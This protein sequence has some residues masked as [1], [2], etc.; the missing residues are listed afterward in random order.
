MAPEWRAVCLPPVLMNEKLPGPFYGL[1][2]VD[3][4]SRTI[5]SCPRRAG[6]HHLFDERRK[7]ELE[8]LSW[9]AVWNADLPIHSLPAEVLLQIFKE[10]LP[11]ADPSTK[12]LCFRNDGYVSRST[13]KRPWTRLMGVCRQWCALIRNAECFWGDIVDSEDPHW[14]KTALPRLGKGFLRARLNDDRHLEGTIPILLKHADQLKHLNISARVAESNSDPL[15]SLLNSPLPVLASLQMSLQ[16]SYHHEHPLGRLCFPD[17]SYPSLT[18]L[19][20]TRMSLS[21]TTSLLGHLRTLSLSSCELSTPSLALS[22]FLDILGDGQHLEDLSLDRFLSAALSPQ[23]F[24]SRVRLVALPKLRRLRLTET[25]F[26]IARLLG[27]INVPNTC[28]IFLSG[29]SS[30]YD[31]DPVSFISMLPQE[32][33]RIAFVGFTTDV[34]FV[35]TRLDNVIYCRSPLAS[36][37]LDLRCSAGYA[38][39]DHWLGVGLLQLVALFGHGQCTLTSLDITGQLHTAHSSIWLKVLAAFPAL[40]TLVLHGYNTFPSSAAQA[41]ATPP[42]VGNWEHGDPS[43]P[44]VCCP[45]LKHLD[46]R[47]WDWGPGAVEA[48]LDCL[49]ARAALGAPELES[50]DLTAHWERAEEAERV[51]AW[52]PYLPR[53]CGVAGHIDVHY[54]E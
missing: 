29:R 32:R 42:V 28:S 46:I 53:L 20:L 33:A 37:E 23:S 16:P 11:P 38:K 13:Y 17:K 3:I 49:G 9:S 48:I 5:Q 18:S 35:M 45:S 6:K 7:F 24:A 40:Q 30:Y 54:S 41:L 1:P 31:K 15:A 22:G 36:C 43:R 21:W 39:G 51:T 26:D 44:R 47:G 10:F 19:K 25:P 52:A 12:A 27:H 34:T 2:E 8:L 50:L 4:N 14:L